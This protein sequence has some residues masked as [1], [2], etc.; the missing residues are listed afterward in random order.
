[1]KIKPLL[2][3][4]LSLFSLCALAQAP[5]DTLLQASKAR[6]LSLNYTPELLV[7]KVKQINGTKDTFNY[8]FATTAA[9][10]SASDNL[11]LYDDPT[12]A[13]RYSDVDSVLVV[14]TESALTLSFI[15]SEGK[16]VNNTFPLAAAPDR[17]IRSWTGGNEYSF[18]I[19]ISSGGRLQWN[20]ISSGISFGFATPVN[21]SVPMNP[22]MGRSLEWT[23]NIIAGVGAHCGRSTFKTGLGMRFMDINTVSR[24]YFDKA[25]N[26]Q[27]VLRP[28]DENV[29]NVKSGFHMFSLQI[30]LFY[31]LSFGRDWGAT[32]GPIVNF[33]VGA[34]L[35]TRYKAGDREYKVDTRAIGQRI[36]TVD[37]M[38]GLTVG[39]FGLYA[40]YCP[41]NVLRDRAGL[42]FSTFSTGII[43]AF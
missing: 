14:A 34:H 11:E 1:M 41:M 39:G 21:S 7:L 9:A 23:W 42:E 6:S 13:L 19:P 38:F 28:Y 31:R 3:A 32:I 37:A 10:A 24:Q 22:S 35:T 4:L 30:P 26:G 40:R 17:T 2:T 43:V 12:V 18:G 25:D 8:K 33:N 15:D 20:M 29:S 27:I 36:V 5:A 16:P